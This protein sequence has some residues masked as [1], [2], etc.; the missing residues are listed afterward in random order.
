MD[1]PLIKSLNTPLSRY[2]L[3]VLMTLLLSSIKGLMRMWEE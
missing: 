2:L 3:V 1:N